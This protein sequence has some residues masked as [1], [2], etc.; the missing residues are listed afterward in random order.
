[1]VKKLKIEKK[2]FFKL[3]KDDKNRYRKLVS[4]Y[5]IKRGDWFVLLHVRENIYQ[6]DKNYD[7]L[8]FLKNH[9]CLQN[10]M[11]FLHLQRLPN[12]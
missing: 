12:F 6:P 10:K 7:N 3:N 1:M 2:I 4:K 9:L 11:Q 5:G 8:D